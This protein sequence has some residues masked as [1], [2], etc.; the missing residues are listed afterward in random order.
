MGAPSPDNLLDRIN[1]T[2][3]RAIA[4]LTLLMVVVT[5]V[6]VVMRYVFDAGLIWVQES[7][8][9]MHAAVFMLGAAYT[10]RDEEHVRVDVFYREMSARRR[11]WVDLVGV[12]LFLL[13]LC[14]F[15]AWNSFDFVNQ[16][17]SIREAS[18]ESGGLPYPLIPM[19]KSILLLMPLAV[20]LQGISLL[21]K[22]LQTLRG[23]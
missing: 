7:V 14:V 16:S 13:P 12:I 3:G 2:I 10:L 8:T 22:S 4:W 11:A 1:T 19:L 6:V 21:L 9:W 5:F 23:R 20:S 18:R 17:W 15:L